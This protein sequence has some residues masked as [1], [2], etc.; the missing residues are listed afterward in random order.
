MAFPSAGWLTWTLK[1][2]EPICTHTSGGSSSGSSPVTAATSTV[3]LSAAASAASRVTN[4]P[5]SCGSG[6]TGSAAEAIGWIRTCTAS[7]QDPGL[8]AANSSVCS[9]LRV[10]I[11]T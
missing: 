3:S 1:R 7:P 8:T 2:A 9:A 5:P 10:P 6:S 4:S 11:W